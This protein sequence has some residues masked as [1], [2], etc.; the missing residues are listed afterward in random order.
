[1]HLLYNFF[2]ICQGNPQYFFASKQFLVFWLIFR[3][4]KASFCADLQHI[5]QN[6]MNKKTDG[7]RFCINRAAK[8]TG[9]TITVHPAYF[10]NLY[11]L[12]K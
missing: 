2:S 8:I 11:V 3:K 10:E 1:M 6:E 9:H 5:Y 4:R 12:S 7:I